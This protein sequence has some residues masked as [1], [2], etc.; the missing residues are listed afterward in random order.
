MINTDILDDIKES[1]NIA[2]GM[3]KKCDYLESN[4]RRLLARILRAKGLVVHEEVVLPYTFPAFTNE[5]LEPIPFGHGFVDIVIQTATG[6]ILLELKIT[7]KDCKRQL[8]KYLRHWRYTPL[9]YGCTVN[10]TKSKCIVN[11][12]K[13]N[14]ETPI[15]FEGHGC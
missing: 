13:R 6:S 8:D 7:D 3:L 11:E 1:C 5:Q 15:I 12:H 14:E 9:L 4:F 2:Y 10:F